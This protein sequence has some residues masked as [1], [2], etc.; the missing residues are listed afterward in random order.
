MT[1]YVY[2]YADANGVGRELLGGKGA[3]L[4]EMT[5]LGIPVPAGFTATTAAC[6]Q[7]M[8]AEHSFPSGFEAQISEAVARLE[9]QARKRFGDQND[10]L[11][12]SVRSGAAVSMPGMMDTILNLGL[13][14][15]AVKG[16]AEATGNTWFAYDSYR[17]LV[18]MYGDVVEGVSSHLFEDALAAMKSERSVSDDAE[19]SGEDMMRV[20]ER[21]KVIYAE[22]AGEP[23]PQNA[24][25]QL[26]RAIRAV[27][28]S[29]DTS[30]AQA[31]RR[32]NKIPHDIG[33]A[34][35]IVQMVFGN[36]GD[37]SGT[38]VCFTRD[39]ST[40]EPG[41]WGEFLVNAQGEDV[42]AGIRTPEPIAAMDRHLPHAYEHL[43]DTIDRLEAHY[44]DMQD[45]EFTVEDGE[46][47]LL[48]TRTGKASGS[49]RAPCRC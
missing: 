21:F 7:Y 45:I 13:G 36:K 5:A 14:D 11:L 32:A 29:W 47:Y 22:N 39:P 34:A 48:Q 26:T 9:E 2:D 15:D 49:G 24:R 12:V 43:V 3:G 38:G 10:P 31:Y 25:D 19:L 35:N 16:L 17:R 28:D 20:A 41:I 8:Q 18:Q 4:A 42:V 46:L 6:V 30:R 37:A 33:T 27:F 40:G 23:F 44:R 1:R